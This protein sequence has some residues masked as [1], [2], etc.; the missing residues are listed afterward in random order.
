MPRRALGT[1]GALGASTEGGMGG[2]MVEALAIV[3]MVIVIMART[4]GLDTPTALIPIFMGGYSSTR[5]RY[6]SPLPPT[7]AWHRHPRHRLHL[8]GT[9]A[10]TQQ[11]IIQWCPRVWCPGSR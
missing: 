1:G 2:P 8:C 3:M 9:T 5:T 6:G 10:Q 11:A 4:T 7:L